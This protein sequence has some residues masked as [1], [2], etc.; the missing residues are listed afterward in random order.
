[1]KNKPQYTLVLIYVLAILTLAI[2]L[3]SCSPQRRYKRLIEKHPELIETDTVEVH[4]TTIY[5]VE[6]PVPEY[7]DSFVI[8]NDTVIETEKLIITKFKDQFHVVVKKDT[9]NVR[10]TI[11]KVVKVPGKVYTKTETNWLWVIIAACASMCIGLYF[12]FKTNK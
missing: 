9:I 5:E 7:R 11:T 2:A 1:M 4:D 8:K 6:V 3:T 10:D 12:G